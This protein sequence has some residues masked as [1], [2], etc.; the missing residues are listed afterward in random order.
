MATTLRYGTGFRGNDAKYVIRKKT[1]I[2]FYE[3]NGKKM[4]RVNKSLSKST[5]TNCSY[6]KRDSISPTTNATI[7]FGGMRRNV[8]IG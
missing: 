8:A 2:Q 4:I 5:V 7:A 1:T 6:D 3:E